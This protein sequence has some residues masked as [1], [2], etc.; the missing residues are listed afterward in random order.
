MARWLMQP[1]HPLTARVILNRYW[2]MLFG[3]GFVKTGEDF[4]SQG[5]WPSH[6]DLLDWLA[7]DFVESGWNIKQ[8]VMSAD[9]EARFHRYLPIVFVAGICDYLLRWT[10]RAARREVVERSPVPRLPLRDIVVRLSSR[11]FAD[12]HT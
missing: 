11:I 6:P 5:E 10:R 8:I 3:T 4:G 7:V 2:S 9:P 12:G 1:N